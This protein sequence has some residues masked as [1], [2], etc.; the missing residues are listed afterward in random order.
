M[1]ASSFRKDARVRLNP[2]RIAECQRLTPTNS[3]RVFLGERCAQL[4]DPWD[5]QD[6]ALTAPEMP[7]RMPEERRARSEFTLGAWRRHLAEDLVEA[8]LKELIRFLT[9]NRRRFVSDLKALNL[10]SASILIIS[11]LPRMDEAIFMV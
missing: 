10:V 5:F 3:S 11:S 7:G 4:I 9:S 1:T 6:T 8:F 2:C